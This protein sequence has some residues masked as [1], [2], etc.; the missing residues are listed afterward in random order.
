MDARQ[1]QIYD[2]L[3]V[4]YPRI[5]NCEVRPCLNASLYEEVY[6]FR[7]GV[8]INCVSWGLIGVVVWPIILILLFMR[9]EPQI[10][11]MMGEK[12]IQIKAAGFEASFTR[13]QI[14]AAAALGAAS[15]RKTDSGE[16]EIA[17]P[18]D[19]ADTLARALPDAK[20][21]ESLSS[22][23]VLWVDDRPENNRYERASL[24]ALGV[25]FDLSL[26]TEDALTKLRARNYD[27]IISDMGRPPDPQAGYTLLDRLRASGDQTPYIIY[28]GSRLPEHVAQ[29]KEHGAVGCTNS[30]RE[31]ISMATKEIR[32]ADAG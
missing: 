13:P 27:L 25:T 10:K 20:A 24:E 6:D 32:N 29:A 17:S 2:S 8:Y 12:D 18:S 22:A 30:A 31:L 28:A 9:L 14:E 15:A 5:H 3:V 11:K 23:R 4:T 7:T 26:S 19:V 16:T 21:Q 1:V